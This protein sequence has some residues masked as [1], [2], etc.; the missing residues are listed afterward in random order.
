MSRIEEYKGMVTQ[1]MCPTLL[2]LRNVGGEQTRSGDW[3][4]EAEMDVGVE[5]VVAMGVEILGMSPRV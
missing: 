2:G 3:R 5:V 1:M 4:E